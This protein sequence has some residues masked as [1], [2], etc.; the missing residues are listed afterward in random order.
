[1]D[2]G[3]YWI[4][5][6]GQ[7]ELEELH[8]SMFWGD[9]ILRTTGCMKVWDP[10]HEMARALFLCKRILYLKLLDYFFVLVVVSQLSTLKNM[11]KPLPTWAWAVEKGSPA[12][13]LFSDSCH[14]CFIAVTC[15]WAY[16]HHFFQAKDGKTVMDKGKYLTLWSRVGDWQAELCFCTRAWR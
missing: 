14:L 15:A 7:V 13:V 10:G 11:R 2:P 3:F 16:Q 5:M 1:M 6:L 8:E 9:V 4:L 12:T